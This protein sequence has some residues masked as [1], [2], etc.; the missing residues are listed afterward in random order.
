MAQPR[1]FIGSSLESK[2]LAE[3]L[4]VL[5]EPETACQVWDQGIH[6]LSAGFLESLTDKARDF[7]FAVFVFGPDDLAQI[8]GVEEFMTRDNVVFET[9]LFMGA[10]GRDRIFWLVPERVDGFHLPTNLLGVTAARYD[11]E[12]FR[13]D[14]RPALGKAAALIK[15]AIRRVDAPGAFVRRLGVRVKDIEE[16]YKITGL[17]YAYHIRDEAK[18]RMLADMRNAKRSISM[19]ARVYISELMKHTT[20]LVE[21]LFHA[22]QAHDCEELLFSLASTSSEDEF[23]AAEVWRQ[24]D[25]QR[26]WW[27]TLEEYREHLKKPELFFNSAHS[28]LGDRLAH[29]PL[30]KRRKVRFKRSY[31]RECLLPYSMV[32]IDACVLYVSFYSLSPERYG[33]FAPTMRLV[34]DSEGDQT[35]ASSFL[36]EKEDIDLNYSSPGAPL[37]VL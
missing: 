3:S 18:D 4:Q 23:L 2:A 26:K 7:D 34:C 31:L 5:L 19:Y 17:S 15:E 10:L 14:G 37:P 20:R 13:Q 28:Q 35:W 6:D 25:P 12:R 1:V 36:K 30:E 22:A 29:L 32:V 11:I 16:F 9:G 8:R 27:T 21:A 24:E 33:T